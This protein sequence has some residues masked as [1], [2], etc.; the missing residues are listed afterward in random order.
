MRRD[1]ASVINKHSDEQ[2][3]DTPDY[4]LAEFLVDCLKAFH[5]STNQ[6][7]MHYGDGMVERPMHSRDV[8]FDGDA[9]DEVW[10]RD[11]TALAFDLPPIQSDQ[12]ARIFSEGGVL[13][14][15]LAVFLQRNAEYGDGAH[16]LGSRGQYADINRKVIKLKRYLWD[17][18]PVRPGAEDVE[19]IA[20]EL[21]GHLLLLLDELRQP[22]SDGK[23]N[24]F[25][26]HWA[27]PKLDV[28][29][30]RYPQGDDD[31]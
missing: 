27:R 19:T 8:Y 13:E 29:G 20:A 31:E 30:P 11:K 7:R 9:T 14:W 1:F 15:T 21:I 26:Q 25:T 17:G 24:K 23:Q 4:V 10:P 16:N 12:A 3:S 28:D 18:E 5:E 2:H 6:R 22:D